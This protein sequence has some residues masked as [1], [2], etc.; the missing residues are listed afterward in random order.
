MQKLPRQKR[1]GG[2][3][4]RRATGDRMRMKTKKIKETPMEAEDRTQPITSFNAD[5]FDAAS[6]PFLAIQHQGCLEIVALH[7]KQLLGRPTKESIPDIPLNAPFVSRKHGLFMTDGLHVRYRALSGTNGTYY[8]GKLLK[9]MDQVQLKDGDSLQIYAG[10]RAG[11]FNDIKIELA[12]S[13]QRQCAWTDIEKAQHDPLTGLMTRKLFTHW[14]KNNVLKTG[15]DACVFIL[16]VDYFKQIN[17]TYGHQYGDLALVTL[18]NE[19]NA[20]LGKIGKVGRWGGDEFVGLIHA[21]RP[22]TAALLDSVRSRLSM[23]KIDG[24][25]SI[26]IS[27]GATAVPMSENVSLEQLLSVADKALYD[28]KL[29]GR[30]QVAF[31]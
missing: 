10:R 11:G 3:Q 15:S 30:N 9:S 8:C 6:Q 5:M 13:R 4:R 2:I 24:R 26:T 31:R 17:D 19:L 22:R 18:A 16:D 25:F 28:A 21:S 27:A 1:A 29:R 14:F 7:G 23:T 20:V 12:S